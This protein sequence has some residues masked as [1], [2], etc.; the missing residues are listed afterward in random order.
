MQKMDKFIFPMLENIK[1]HIKSPVIPGTQ[2]DL[3]SR[4]FKRENW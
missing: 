2:L 4:N 1:E 3:V